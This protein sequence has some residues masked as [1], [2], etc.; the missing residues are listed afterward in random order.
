MCKL[1]RKK[2]RPSNDLERGLVYWHEKTKERTDISICV[3]RC[4][5]CTSVSVLGTTG[6]ETK[7]LMIRRC[8]GDPGSR[9]PRCDDDCELV[10]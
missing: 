9:V 4:I 5:C 1:R 3:L 7:F 10:A 8:M 6:G 2:K